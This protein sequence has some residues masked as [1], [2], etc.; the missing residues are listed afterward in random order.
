M[1]V[2]GYASRTL[3]PVEKDCHL[4]SGKL[5]FSASKWSIT[6]AFKCY[7][8]HASNLRVLTDNNPLTY[9]MSTVK[10]TATGMQ[11]VGELAEYHFD[12]KYRPDR[13]SADVDT[14]SSMSMDID[15]YEASCSEDISKEAFIASVNAVLSNVTYD[16]I[17]TIGDVVS[18]AADMNLK[19]Y[20]S[21]NN[22]RLKKVNLVDEQNKDPNISRILQFKS[23]RIRPSSKQQRGKALLCVNCCMNLT[24]CLFVMMEFF[25]VRLGSY[26]GSVTCKFETVVVPRIT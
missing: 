23:C 25:V 21:S 7:L 10:L 16:Y 22:A 19:P 14:L 6:E 20:A 8:C 2:I 15:E 4:H 3:T 18:I 5:K 9:V 12:I 17:T 26:P 11:W 1:R 24:D 13:V